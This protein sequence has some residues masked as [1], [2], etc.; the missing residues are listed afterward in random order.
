MATTPTSPNPSPG[1]PKKVPTGGRVVV[2]Q[3]PPSIGDLDTGDTGLPYSYMPSDQ[4]QAPDETAQT[5]RMAQ[6]GAHGFDGMS[7]LAGGDNDVWVTVP[8]DK[9]S[10][11]GGSAQVVPAYGTTRGGYQPAASGSKVPPTPPAGRPPVTPR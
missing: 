2:P 1:K 3:V 11:S 6:T 7:G 4:T 5:G 9:V 10:V 8:V